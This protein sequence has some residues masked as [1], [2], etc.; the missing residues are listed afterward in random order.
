[1]NSTNNFQFARSAKAD[2]VAP[3]QQEI[4]H[5]VSCYQLGKWAEA[6]QL[7]GKLTKNY[8]SHPFSWKV[9]GAI[10]KMTGKAQEALAPMIHSVRLSP[11]DA[12]VHNNLGA[13]L[14]DLGR[15]KD[16]EVSCRKAIALS[17]AYPAAHN[18]LG[19]ALSRLGRL[20][21]AEASCR[22]A[23]LLSPN[24][25]EAFG[26]LANTLSA[27][28][29][30]AEAEENYR[31]ALKITPTVAEL[32]HNLGIT[33]G[34]LGRPTQAQVCFRE[35]I[36]LKSDY[37][38]AYFNLG[39]SIKTKD[40]NEA[41][42][43]YQEAI[44]LKPNF[45]EAHNNL[46]VLL[47]NLGQLSEAEV[48][49]RRAIKLNPD[50]VDAHNNLG[51]VLSEL[52]RSA[53]AELSLRRAIQLQPNFAHA[54][55][56]LGNVLNKLGRLTEAEASHRQ[57]VHI[58]RHYA[59]GHNNLGN[60]LKELG[61]LA[62]AETC[63]RQ[64]I[65]L[66][67]DY[68]NAHS[69]LLFCQNYSASQWTET[70]LIDAKK[71]GDLVSANAVPKFTTWHIRPSS[72]KLRV[73]FVS[74][75]LRTH[76]VGFFV[77]GLIQY[78]DRSRF[79]LF[80]F[81]TTRK[82][83]ELTN[84]LRS[85]FGE[86]TPIDRMTDFEAATLIHEKKIDILID[87]SGHSAYNRLTVFAYKPAPVQI[88]WLGYFATTGLPEMDYFLGDPHMSPHHEAHH[89]TE[90][91]WPLAETWLCFTPPPQE[92]FPIAESPVSK[93]GYVTFGCFGNLT[94]VTDAVVKTWASILQNIPNS[95]MFLKAK[96]LLDA[97]VVAS[98]KERFAKH[99]VS[100]DRL[101]L[102]GSSSRDEYLHSYGRVD[103]MLDTFPYPGGTASVEALWMSV[104][105]LTLRGNRFLS[106]LGES[107]ANNA[108]QHDWIACDVDDYIS[109]AIAFSADIAGLAKIRSRLR[110]QVLKT[111]L[112]DSKRF[113]HHFGNTMTAIINCAL[114]PLV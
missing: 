92:D 87:L 22:Q 37:A 2:K 58:D 113:A 26:N 1:M 14:N 57:A 24:Y 12:E 99:G 35:A 102:E 53:E 85:N 67:P 19:V 93:H 41:V 36:R 45:P 111:S 55:N 44:K 13:V 3:T 97:G 8:P 51:V 90:T 80:A 94:K 42:A 50:F 110:E 71:Y 104:P 25:A 83:D 40:T 4:N 38:E 86:W 16:A 43:C 32:H 68:V 112:F 46:G 15:S 82:D 47:K 21:D 31:T 109:K 98:T 56:N 69:N 48:C 74:G 52:R 108:E 66:K 59:Q 6:E 81:P 23:I 11:L 84:R 10:L 30:L 88:S 91:V 70:A 75:D 33:L 78:L 27:L 39:D 107:I 20:A 63:Y 100:Q 103:M 54:H 79:E 77:E 72:S 95:T 73:G 28:G 64:A 7:A 29:R 101:I 106:H 34:Q 65:L 9:L 17:P 5:L 114:I 105:V 96:Q 76:S 60:T 49:Q 18:N 89:F 62:E 61:R